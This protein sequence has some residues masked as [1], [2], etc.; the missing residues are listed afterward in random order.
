V[1]FSPSLR[2]RASTSASLVQNN[3]ILR[4]PAPRNYLTPRHHEGT[5]IGRFGVVEAAHQQVER[6]GSLAFDSCSN[7]GGAISGE[8]ER[9][10]MTEDIVGVRR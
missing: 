1:P 8:I 7:I 3:N 5:K 10:S 9:E 2:T 4:E 6:F